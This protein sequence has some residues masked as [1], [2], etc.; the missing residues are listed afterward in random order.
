MRQRRNARTKC[1]SAEKTSGES[2]SLKHPP[3]FQSQALAPPFAGL[4]SASG[5]LRSTEAVRPGSRGDTANLNSRRPV[6]QRQAAIAYARTD[7]FGMSMHTPWVALNQFGLERR[8]CALPTA[9]TAQQTPRPARALAGHER[10]P[11]RPGCLNPVG[12]GKEFGLGS[13]RRGGEVEAPD[14]SKGSRP[15]SRTKDSK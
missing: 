8:L 9:P 10:C 13:L 15:D 7:C 12:D 1:A 6:R 2:G 3:L 14:S 5:S 4:A 11:S